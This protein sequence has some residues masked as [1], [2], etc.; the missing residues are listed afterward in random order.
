MLWGNKPP[1]PFVSQLLNSQYDIIN[2]FSVNFN[3]LIPKASA[4][5]SSAV[6]RELNEEAVKTEEDKLNDKRK[7][8][9]FLQKPNRPIPKTKEELLREKLPQYKV[10]IVKQPKPRGAPGREP[11]PPP[12]VVEEVVDEPEVSAPEE[13]PEE[14]QNIEQ[15]ATT[16]TEECDQEMSSEQIEEIAAETMDNEVP[17]LVGEETGE[18]L[19]GIPSELEKQLAD[20]QKQLLAL[21]NLPQA[22]QATLDAVTNELAKIVPVIKEVSRQASMDRDY[23]S[24]SLSRDTE[25]TT[26]MMVIEETVE[27]SLELEDKPKEDADVGEHEASES[28]SQSESSQEDGCSMSSVGTPV[29]LTKEQQLEEHQKQLK[30]A[31][32]NRKNDVRVQ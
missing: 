29:A 23:R 4:I 31:I 5:K 1:S 11:T 3:K 30:A 25:P 8:T 12:V 14:C 32:E 2:S 20:V 28:C 10:N 7:W 13:V 15:E 18:Q 6:L 21:S 19:A 27:E 16:A 9:K 17:D 22:I 24:R 26:E